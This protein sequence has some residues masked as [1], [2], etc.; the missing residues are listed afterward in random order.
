MMKRV[1]QK[2]FHEKVLTLDV[3]VS[4]QGS[5]PYT[6]VFTLRYG[7]E[8]GRIVRSFAPGTRHPEIEQYFIQDDYCG[9][10]KNVLK[11]GLV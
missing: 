1:T 2:E 10:G 4:I 11:G 7:S 5:Y 9:A 3:I 6:S 8:V